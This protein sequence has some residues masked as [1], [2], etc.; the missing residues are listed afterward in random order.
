MLINIDPNF[1]TLTITSEK[2]WFAKGEQNL[3]ESNK[4]V[5]IINN[6]YIYNVSI[7]VIMNEKWNP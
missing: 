3:T 7:N 4:V 2:V 1:T 6:I 5:T